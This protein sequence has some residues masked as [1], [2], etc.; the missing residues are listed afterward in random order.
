MEPNL[1]VIFFSSQNALVVPNNNVIINKSLNIIFM[2]GS[3]F[4]RFGLG[5]WKAWKPGGLKA[6]KLGSWKARKPGC[7]KIQ[8]VLTFS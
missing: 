5:S 8:L 1:T 2:V 7:Q 3:P 6:G 4:S